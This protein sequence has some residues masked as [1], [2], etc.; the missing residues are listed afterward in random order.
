MNLLFSILF[1]FRFFCSL[2][3]LKL[4][5]DYS[6]CRPYLTSPKFV[7]LGSF[8]GKK[9][10]LLSMNCSST[11]PSSDNG[12]EFSSDRVQQMEGNKDAVMIVD[13]GSRREESNLMLSK[14]IYLFV[15]IF[16]FELKFQI[17]PFW[18]FD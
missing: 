4:T 5:G 3:L 11:S 16:T 15:H 14:F 10:R 9:S 7:K 17:S 6:N 18:Y 8:V 13:H 2:C 1:I 12:I